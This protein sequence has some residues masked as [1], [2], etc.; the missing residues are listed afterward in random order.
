MGL[1]TDARKMHFSLE[2]QQNNPCDGLLG[3]SWTFSMELDAGYINC[4][5]YLDDYP[6][7]EELVMFRSYR[8]KP[9]DM[10]DLRFPRR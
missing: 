7:W 4:T 10:R 9:R 8:G 5:R 6:R 1:D 3:S 2:T